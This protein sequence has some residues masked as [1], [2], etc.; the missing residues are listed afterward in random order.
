MTRRILLFIF[1]AVHLSIGYARQTP[2]QSI[3]HSNSRPNVLFI[4]IDDMNDWISI[5]DPANPIRTPNLEKLAKRGVFFSRAY[6]SSPSCNPSRASFLTGTRPHKTGIYGNKS[7]WRAALPKAETIQQYFMKNGYYSAGAGKIF[8]HHWDGA[9]HDNA[10]FDDFQPMPDIYPDAPMPTKKLNGLEWWGTKNSDWGAWPL[11]AQD[12]VDYKTASYAESFLAKGHD[13]PFFLSIGIFRPHMPFFSPPE[14]IAQYQKTAGPVMPAVKKDDWNDL[15]SGATKLM[16]ENKWFWQGIEKAMTE[17]PKTWQTMVTGYQAAATFADQQIGR[18]LDALEKSPYQNNT[19]IVLL[20][21]HGYHLGEKQHLEK[22]ALWEK[23]THIPFI[24][25]APGQIAPG[26]TI[27][28]PVDLTTVY[29]TLIDLCRLQKKNDLDGLSLMPL[30]KN[31]KADFPPALMTYMKG[32]HAIRTGRWR[33]IQYEDGTEELYD[34]SGD[35]N[36]WTNL[37]D[38]K[39][40]QQIKEG[41][42]KYIPKESADPVK[43]MIRPKNTSNKVAKP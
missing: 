12:A 40:L 8:H 24:W 35:S 39:D 14:N 19:I 42:K 36:E 21:D 37:A 2:K 4:T 22:F 3:A 26:T 5:F 29:P 20:S 23:T 16:E 1:L 33:Y 7:D 10:S 11:K 27:D 28:K 43:D 6:A 13:R 9:F 30:F 15:P 25:V 32:N 41:L 17:D 38:K 18:V 31:P 34:H